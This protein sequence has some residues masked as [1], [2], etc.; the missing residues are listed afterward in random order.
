MTSPPQ[1]QRTPS[2]GPGVVRKVLS[3]RTR[4]RRLIQMS[5]VSVRCLTDG[6]Y[7]QPRSLTLQ[8]TSAQRAPRHSRSTP[9]ASRQCTGPVSDVP[10]GTA[11]SRRPTDAISPAFPV[12][13]PKCR[14][15]APHTTE[16]AKPASNLPS[17]SPSAICLTVPTRYPGDSLEPHMRNGSVVV[18]IQ[19]N[20]LRFLAKLAFMRAAAPGSLIISG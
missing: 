15:P 5:A 18:R 12:P 1:T 14:V 4:L 9:E 8:P 6:R 19:A 17:R 13:G 11:R 10:P 3:R 2:H 20:S 7:L 16:G